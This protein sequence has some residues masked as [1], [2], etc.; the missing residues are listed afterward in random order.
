[1]VVAGFVISGLMFLVVDLLRTD[2]RELTLEQTQQDMKRALD[3]ISDD[4]REA[5]FVYDN[6][7]PLVTA[8]GATDKALPADAVPVL[9]FWKIQGL[10][11]DANDYTK[12]STPGTASCSGLTGDPLANCR[13]LLVRHGYYELVVYYSTALPDATWEG[14]ARIYRY[15]VPEYSRNALTDPGTTLATNSIFM[16]DGSASPVQGGSPSPDFASWVPNDSGTGTERGDAL[17]DYVADLAAGAAPSCEAGYT[18]FPAAANVSNSFYVCV[19]PRNVANDFLNQDVTVYL[20]G[21]A[22]PTDTSLTVQ[23]VSENT[24]LPTLQTR[25]LVR[26]VIDKD[27]PN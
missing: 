2:Q 4:L 8:L 11:E 25:T 21:D 6:P 5:V 13:A 3:Y 23:G 24:E 14:A 10:N 9:A 22:D 1:M 7:T 27:L 26:G 18:Q 16:E 20:R 17:V 15:S 19:R 12:L